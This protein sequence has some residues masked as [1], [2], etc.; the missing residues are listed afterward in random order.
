[1]FGQQRVA[2][3]GDPTKNLPSVSITAENYNRI[4]RLLEHNVPVKL[5][6]DIKTQVRYDATRI[7][8]T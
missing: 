6:F 7:P 8:S 4:A 1:M 2:A 5:S 3:T